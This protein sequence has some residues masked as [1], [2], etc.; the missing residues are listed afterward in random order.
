MLCAP[1]PLSRTCHDDESRGLAR[2]AFARLGARLRNT[3][4]Y[5][6]RFD[7]Q[8]ATTT[9]RLFAGVARDAGPTPSYLLSVQRSRCTPW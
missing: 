1:A 6:K 5:R 2:D 8:A 7:N 4:Q 3:I 9:A